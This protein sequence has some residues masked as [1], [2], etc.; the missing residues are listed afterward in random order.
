MKIGVISDT[1]GL[2]RP[3]A[4]TALAGVEQIL[5]AGDIGCAE[6]LEQ[7]N[8]IAP[9][10]AVRGNID[11][12]K[13][14]AS[15]LPDQVELKLLNWRLLLLHDANEVSVADQH[16]Q[17]DLVVSGHSHKPRWQQDGEIRWLNPGSAG[18]RR[19]SLPVSLALLELTEHEICVEMVDL[20]TSRRDSIPLD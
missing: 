13:A 19:F 17:V 12:G 2:L 11:L 14:W 3:E 10:T 20:Q 16:L 5:H 15:H 4:V 1:H 7:L 8:L 6:V 9:A 18:R